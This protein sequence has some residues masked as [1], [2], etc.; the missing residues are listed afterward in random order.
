MDVVLGVAL[1]SSAPATIHTVLVS[2]EN[3]DG[4]TVE[5][6]RF[7]IPTEGAGDFAAVDAAIAAILRAHETAATA[8]LHL[9]STGVT[10]T[11]PLDAAALSA[12]LATSGIANVTLVSPTLAAASL[13]RK[14][15]R[16]TGCDRMALLSVESAEATLAVVDCADGAV[17]RLFRQVLNDG[18]ATAAIDTIA[19]RLNTPETCADGLLLV[20]SGVDATSIRPKVE[21]AVRHVVSMPGEP[22]VALARGAAL[23][24]AHLAVAFEASAA[25][26]AYTQ[27]PDSGTIVPGYYDI[28]EL[29]ADSGADDLAYSAIPDE[30]ADTVT[31]VIRTTARP[32]R[33][34]LLVAGAVLASTAFAAASALMVALALDITPSIVALRP[35][36]G[37]VL[38]M[39]A[40]PHLQFPAL[41]P[42]VQ[43]PPVMRRAPGDVA[44]PAVASPTL[45]AAISVPPL[46]LPTPA[47]L[48]APPAPVFGPPL[49]L[50]NPPVHALMAPAPFTRTAPRVVP[51]LL[52]PLPLFTPTP[53]LSMPKPPAVAPTPP[54]GRPTPPVVKPTPPV[55]LPTPPVV[56]PNPPVVK[57]I[58]PVVIPTA[59]VV[60]PT[61]PAITP[62]L[63]VVKP[64]PLA[65]KPVPPVSV[66]TPPVVKPVP[67]ITLPTPPVVIPTPP[68]APPVSL[69]APPV[70]LPAPQ[71][72]VSVPVAPIAPALPSIPAPIAPAL[73]SIPTP[74][75]PSLPSLGGGMPKIPSLFGGGGGGFGGG[76]PSMPK[77][78]SLFGGGGGGL[79]GL[80]GAK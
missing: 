52:P 65:I 25:P 20:G 34:P 8:G 14:M 4:I 18:D 22:E 30:Q 53:P 6:S 29:S 68:V 48:A 33:R 32:T 17:T 2:G 38:T 55:V 35:E 61:P 77:M 27:D 37:R 79:G 31:E 5:E 24:S 44:A 40:A 73:P 13:A 49:P 41:Q 64:I 10:V 54:T 62:N 45:P 26:L 23:A 72:P 12:R 9:V 58:V 43:Q 76:M 15:G 50:A 1:V 59:P 46:D 56:K 28:P 67:P 39:P 57:P 80:F 7:D 66:P 11:N 74:Q 78:P 42:L 70:S 16:A 21:A 19:D 71:A 47:P 60:V 36:L 69:P 75:T 3:G 63:P 51:L